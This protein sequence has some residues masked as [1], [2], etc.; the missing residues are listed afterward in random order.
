MNGLYFNSLYRYLGIVSLRGRLRT[1]LITFITLMVLL[2]SIPFVYFEKKHLQENANETI[3]KT[4]QVQQV[5]ISNWL[6]NRMSNILAI[7]GLPSV[8][9]FDLER[10][11]IAF[12]SFD[13][14]HSEFDSIVYINEEG[15]SEVHTSGIIGVDFSD[16]QYFLEA[17]KGNSHI[18]DVLIG[19]QSGEQIITVSNPIYD[20]DGNFKGVIFGTVLLTTINHIMSQFQDESS[21][22]YLVDR[23]GM[24]ITKSSLGEVG[25]V[26]QTDIYKS[27]LGGTPTP[28]LYETPNG[29]RVLGNY[30]WVHNDQWLIIGEITEDK[31]N[32][33]FYSMGL[34]FI[35]IILFGS[36][37]GLLLLKLVSTQIET[38]IR[39]V[40]EGSKNVGE[41]KFNY[42]IEPSSYEKDAIEFQELCGNFND[43]NDII[44][45]YIVTLKE[46][47]ERL[48]MIIEHSSD[49]IT[50]HDSTG[51]YLYVSPAGKE[52]LQYEDHEVIGQPSKFFIHPDDFESTDENLKELLTDGYAVSTYRIRRKDGQYIWFETSLKCLKEKTG[53]LQI[54]AISR[55]I[56]ERK[57]TEQNLE[58]ANRLLKDLSVK[59]GLTGIWNR[60]AFD[61]RLQAEW[62]QALTNSKT[63]SLIMLDIDYFKKYNDTYGHQAGDDCLRQVANAIGRAAEKTHDSVFRY[64]GEEFSVL[65]PET[66][67]AGAQ[68]V[69]EKIRQAVENLNM[70]HAASKA[71]PIVTVSL[72]INTLLPTED[73]TIDQF[74]EGADQALYHA[75]QNGR[76]RSCSFTNEL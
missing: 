60:R 51:Q 31:I 6:K 62:S 46:K 76:N 39:R 38:P 30:R 28:H 11:E 67:S 17:K 65:L 24:L 3:E 10:I 44:E 27:A 68:H 64:G 25:E 72:G 34:M 14:S 59:D 23:S 58:E 50:I 42:R 70:S 45:N 15:I 29:E 36:M 7:S 66:D 52:V 40:L 19:R 12:K 55:N 37:I 47:E 8:K 9:D 69:A 20:A 63:L 74:I 56:T 57:M 73:L 53:E 32:K 41:H 21:E 33:T 61:E 48:Q 54:I 18:S 13:N 2:A 26:I 4:I 35:I 22:T 16:R 49:M 5:F 71:S 43:M 1:L 75:K